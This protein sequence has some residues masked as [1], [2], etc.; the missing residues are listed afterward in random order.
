VKIISVTTQNGCCTITTT[1][2]RF[3]RWPGRTIDGDL[4]WWSFVPKAGGRHALVTVPGTIRQL[5]ARCLAARGPALP[6]LR[7]VKGAA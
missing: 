1:D 4:Q 2:G 6:H 7:L 5:E 3:E